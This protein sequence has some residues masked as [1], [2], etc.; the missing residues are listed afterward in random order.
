MRL[1]REQHRRFDKAVH[2]MSSGD[3]CPEYKLRLF[4]ELLGQLTEI[5]ELYD[6]DK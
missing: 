1:L 6:T 3:K 5:R 4:E 2:E